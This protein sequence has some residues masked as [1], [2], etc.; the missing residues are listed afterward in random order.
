MNS[1]ELENIRFILVVLIFILGLSFTIASLIG[2]GFGAQKWYRWYANQKWPP[3]KSPREATRKE[4]LNL[5]VAGFILLLGPVVWF[6]L[7]GN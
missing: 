7:K 6:W 1:Q 3:I 2:Y 5:F 4:R